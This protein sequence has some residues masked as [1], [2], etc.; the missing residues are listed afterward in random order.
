[1]LVL[2][3][4]IL[5]RVRLKYSLQIHQKIRLSM[6]SV[7]P[8]LRKIRRHTVVLVLYLVFLVRLR[9]QLK[10]HLKTLHYTRSLVLHL[11]NKHIEIKEVD[12]CL[13]RLA[14]QKHSQLKRQSLQLYTYS[15]VLQL[16]LL[17][18]THQ[19]HQ[20]LMYTLVPQLR[21]IQNRMSVLAT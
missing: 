3:H 10:I 16:S 20:Q 11:Y 9:L 1:M 5:L 14:L 17:R 2:V 21:R 12:L 6:Y 18:L 8:L 13:L 7:D 15:V 19:K 4:F